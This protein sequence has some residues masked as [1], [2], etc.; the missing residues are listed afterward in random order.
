MHGIQVGVESLHVE[1]TNINSISAPC[2]LQLVLSGL[3]VCTG[4]MV[5]GYPMVQHLCGGL[6]SFM[7]EHGFNSIADFKGASLPY[8][9]THGDLVA[10]QQ[11]AVAERKAAKVGLANDQNWTGDGF[12]AEAESMVSNKA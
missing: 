5:H 7:L 2:W 11:A 12:I 4:V 10:R 9:T 6:H 1:E 8:F 3:Q